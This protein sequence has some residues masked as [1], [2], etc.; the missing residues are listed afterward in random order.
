MLNFDIQYHRNVKKK[1][2][3]HLPFMVHQKQVNCDSMCHRKTTL[4]GSL[5]IQII[6]E[7]K[8]HP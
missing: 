4:N 6:I 8:I 1:S 5:K 2:E 3:V 7:Q